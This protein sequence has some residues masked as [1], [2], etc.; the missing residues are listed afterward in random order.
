[1]KIDIDI[2]KTIADAVTAAIA[3]ERIGEIIKKNVQSTVDEAVNK[4]FGNWSEFSK[5]VQKAV[6]EITPH[7]MTLDKQADWNHFITTAI[8]QR[9]TAYNEQRLTE[10]IMP[11]LD[12]L[13]E[14][15]PESVKL[16]EIVRAAVA[17][18][19]EYDEAIDPHLEVSRSTVG[20]SSVYHNITISKRNSS[21]LSKEIHIA[22]NDKFEVYS[23]RFDS[24]EISKMKFAGPFFN[25]E[26]KLF[27]LYACRTKLEIDVESIEDIDLDFEDND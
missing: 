26:Q 25:I 13:L 18:W 8:N 6:V 23:V 21:Y 3:P 24:S 5:A 20:T 17:H 2:E 12:K 16:S 15:P 4:A 10:V 27:N 7:E 19:R 9:L 22:C 14:K 11:T 1:M